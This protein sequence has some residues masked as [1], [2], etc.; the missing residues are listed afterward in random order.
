MVEYVLVQDDTGQELACLRSSLAPKVGQQ[1]RLTDPAGLW[2]SYEVVVVGEPDA[3]RP[4]PV[5]I[6][7]K[8]IRE[9]PPLPR[10]HTWRHWRFEP[11]L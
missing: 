4:E 11:P 1:L 9:G 2:R 8:K 5:T 6:W 10:G 3:A 7:A